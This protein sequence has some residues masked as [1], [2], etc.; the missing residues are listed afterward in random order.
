MKK[1]LPVL[2]LALFAAAGF[3]LWQRQSGTASHNDPA[4][5][6]PAG[7]I[8]F[9]VLPDLDATRARWPATAL[10]KIGA[11]PE[12]RAFLEK[13]LALLRE[14]LSKVQPSADLQAL[15]PVSAFLVLASLEGNSPK[16]SGGFRHRATPE[17]L[18]AALK[19][20]REEVLKKYPTG[21]TDIV[22]H[23]DTPIET[24]TADDFHLATASF[25]D[26]YF[27]AN[28]TVLIQDMLDRAAHKSGTTPL[29]TSQPFL[30]V[31]KQLPTRM[32]SLIF[33]Q[34]AA[35][36][37]R[38]KDVAVSGGQATKEDLAALEKIKAIGASTAFE[39]PLLRDSIYLLGADQ[40][41]A[42]K[43]ARPAMALANPRTVLFLAGGISIPQKWSLPDAGLDRTG[44]LRTLEGI[45][46]DLEAAGLGPAVLAP[47]FGTEGAL[48]IDW[49][50]TSEYPALLATAEVRD[51]AVVSKL[52]NH[53]AA[54][55]GRTLPLSRA[56]ESG[57]EVFRVST[58]GL[59]PVSP[60]VALSDKRLFL[61]SD[62]K[63]LAA[64]LAGNAT[65]KL[66]AQPAFQQAM[67]S[68]HPPTHTFVYFDLKSVF[69]RA[70][71]TVRP[72]LLFGAG[73]VPG[74]SKN[75]DLTKLPS[76]EAV[77]KHLSPIVFSETAD[78]EGVLM[79]ST[80]PLTL[81][82]FVI[83]GGGGAILGQLQGLMA[84]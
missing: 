67:A 52:L 72:L 16:W 32:E 44:M 19:P 71:G 48:Q 68:L 63:V 15:N 70:Y 47:A 37:G 69:E 78:A 60:T 9:L 81:N 7:A 53:L 2:L 74:L 65:P 46:T 62:E 79:E 29:A 6:A 84:N 20:A 75:A 35:I 49:E 4:S 73:F 82:Q 25:K 56:E 58:G 43:L 57:A 13:P 59:L 55:Q 21:R 26:W 33:L 40:K 66:E 31:R 77:S 54:T 11:E 17:Q 23:G 3:A 14:R 18:T 51:R 34:P 80:G 28:D 5:L 12:V 1:I 30:A 22:Q 42:A 38:I 10:A 61:L 50:P 83:L 45:L 36:V 39:G 64:A 24:F 41:D 76:T 8:A 27:V